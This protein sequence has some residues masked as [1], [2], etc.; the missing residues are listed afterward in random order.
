MEQ[1]TFEYVGSLSFL[2]NTTAKSLLS[3]RYNWWACT[4]CRIACAAES[5]PVDDAQDPFD[6]MYDGNIVHTPLS[7]HHL[8][9]SEDEYDPE[10]D[11]IP[12][13][14]QASYKN[15][16]KQWLIASGYTGR[17]RSTANYSSLDR[18]EQ[19]TFCTQV[20]AIFRHVL[21]QLSP[22]DADQVWEDVIDGE[23][24]T[25]INTKDG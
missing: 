19:T 1:S 7:T 4:S 8:S 3:P 15:M 9:Q 17:Y 21:C 10:D 16:F 22:N 25:P 18:H 23:M 13:P 14:E 2:E 12:S 6:W 5:S 24:K 20:K 11:D